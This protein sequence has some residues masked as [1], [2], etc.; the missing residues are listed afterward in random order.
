MFPEFELWTPHSL[1]EALAQIATAEALPLAGGT[2]VIPDLRSGR[3]K[4]RILLDIS[5]LEELHGIRRENGHVIIGGGVTLGEL[6]ASPSEHSGCTCPE[7]VVARNGCFP[8]R[9]PLGCAAR[10]GRCV[11]ELAT[12]ANTEQD[13]V[14]GHDMELGC[15]FDARKELAYFD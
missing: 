6:L 1:P 7:G 3:H 11:P 14:V 8:G 5:R 9:S 2:N 12:G 15:R 10:P 13:Q 4:A